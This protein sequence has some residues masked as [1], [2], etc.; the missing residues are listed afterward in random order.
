MMKRFLITIL[1]SIISCLG[2]GVFVSHASNG[3]EGVF[4]N[5]NTVYHVNPL[6]ADV[7]DEQYITNSVN[8]VTTLEE[9]EFTSDL[10]EI[11]KQIRQAMVE[12]EA[13]INIYYAF[14]D[15]LTETYLDEWLDLALEETENSNE[16]DYLRWHYERISAGGSCYTYPNGNK[17][18]SI[19]MNFKYYTTRAQ[20]E[21]LTIEVNRVLDQLG[22]VNSMS[23]YQK[24]KKIY[25]YICA[26]ISY[27]YDN[28]N[29][30]SYKLKFTAYA[31]MIHKSAVC[32]GYASLFYRMSNEVGVD[33]RVITG[34]SNGGGHAWN[35]VKLGNKYYNLDSTWDAGS[36]YYSY[37]LCGSNYFSEHNSNEE[38]ITAEFKTKYPISTTNYSISINHTY[39]ATWKYSTNQHWRECVVCGERTSVGSHSMGQWVVVQNATYTKEGT[40]QKKCST[41]EYNEVGEIEK[42]IPTSILI[43]QTSCEIELGENF[44]LS[45]VCE[46]IK[47]EK[48]ELIWSSSDPSVAYVEQN[49]KVISVGVGTTIITA[50]IAESTVSATCEVS[51]FEDTPIEKFVTRLY[52]VCLGRTP[53]KGG[54]SSWSY[55]LE[56]NI[57]TG[58]QVAAHFIFSDEFKGQN[59]CNEDYIEQLYNAFMGRASDFGG[60][61]NWIQQMREGMTREQVFN[62][63]AL[64]GEFR[65]I[66]AEY[67]IELGNGVAVPAI[68]T[69]P[70][71][72]CAACGKEDGV[73]SFV[74]RMYSVCLDR[75]ADNGGLS[76]WCYQLRNHV[77]SGRNVAYYFIFSP[78]FLAKNCNDADYVEYLYR[79]FMGR[80]SDVG[81]KNGWLYWLNHGWSRE[82]V[83]EY[84]VTSQ[85]FTLI[86]GD[87]GIVRG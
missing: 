87:Y 55:Q 3:N 40:K 17:E 52:K 64:S 81:G 25:D 27:D 20:E 22:I 6:Y 2:M 85:E 78:E 29:D 19:T 12:R 54:K 76:S 21:A 16:G 50:T 13:M 80:E 84:F 63:F 32:Q 9:P 60:K 75:E 70:N 7:A 35:I 4:T 79:A 1:V 65:G 38:Y 11:A 69:A 28:L 74:K 53:D 47:P 56:H 71:G 46:P 18:Y 36:Y 83:F 44:V 37:F 73:T 59:L 49:G 5:L 33:A 43:N 24:V 61:L 15:E 86:C 41:C 82:Q 8:Y 39:G 45:V 14:R 72:I 48:E 42:Y 57:L 30:S 31:A 23:D 66:C 10:N 58:S 67:G 34:Y 68:G 51:V 62:G 26:Y 77:L